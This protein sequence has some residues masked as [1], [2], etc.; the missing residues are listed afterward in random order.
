MTVDPATATGS[1]A[2]ALCRPSIS[3]DGGLR[4]SMLKARIFPI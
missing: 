4:T 3:I 1:S 2:E